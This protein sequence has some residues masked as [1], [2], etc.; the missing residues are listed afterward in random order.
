MKAR[1]QEREGVMQ[2][3][4]EAETVEEGVKILQLC[5]RVKSPIKTFGNIQ[6]NTWAWVELPVNKNISN[7]DATR[8]GNIYK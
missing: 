8:F 5:Q 1:I 3:H 2:I 4:L 7:W 6:E